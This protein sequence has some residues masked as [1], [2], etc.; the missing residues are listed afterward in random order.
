M[1][2]LSH[3]RAYA[4]V[5]RLAAEIDGSAAT[6]D[7]ASLATPAQCYVWESSPSAFEVVLTALVAG[8]A[9]A[10]ASVQ[11]RFT[12][13]DDGAP[14]RWSSSCPC[15]AFALQW[16]CGHT[17]AL[18]RAFGSGAL[19]NDSASPPPFVQLPPQRVLAEPTLFTSSN[20]FGNG[21]AAA[22]HHGTAFELEGARHIT[23]AVAG[24]AGPL[25]VANI[26]SSS[27]T[28]IPKRPMDTYSLLGPNFIIPRAPAA[29]TRPKR[30]RGRGRGKGI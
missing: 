18:L 20:Y 12:V 17:T 30:G 10:H 4:V 16:S 24:T 28:A 2:D 27:M 1:G 8:T 3:R 11:S 29:D 21:N 7:A 25:P 26:S 5:T 13:R 23:S 9:T 6:R 14:P 22:D 15:A 19:C